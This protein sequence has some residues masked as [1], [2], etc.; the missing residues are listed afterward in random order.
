MAFHRA[1]LNP[2][3]VGGFHQ[4]H[5]GLALQQQPNLAQHLPLTTLVPLG[6]VHFLGQSVIP[7]RRSCKRC[8]ETTLGVNETREPPRVKG[9]HWAC[10][11]K[12]KRWPKDLSGL[13]NPV[14]KLSTS[15]WQH[16][17]AVEKGH[18]PLHP[19]SVLYGVSPMPRLLAPRLTHCPKP[20]RP[21]YLVKDLGVFLAH[22][23]EKPS[24][25]TRLRGGRPNPSL[26]NCIDEGWCWLFVY[27]L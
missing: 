15:L 9:N 27:M 2:I 17:V 23:K 25:P 8:V 5:R 14:G 26:I 12:G 20:Q 1:D 6:D 21:P 4:A 10:V 7:Q 3:T 19:S 18:D 16:Q 13:T 11:H 22:L 24:F